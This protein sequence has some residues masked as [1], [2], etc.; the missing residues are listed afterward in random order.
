MRGARADRRCARA[1]VV[2]PVCGSFLRRARRLATDGAPAYAAT[3]YVDGGSSS[4]SDGG[5]GS[6]D[7]LLHD[8]EGHQQPRRAR[9]DHPRKPAIYGRCW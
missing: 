1:L 4:C 3:Y 9:R 8:H 2:P 5:S 7:T 6:R